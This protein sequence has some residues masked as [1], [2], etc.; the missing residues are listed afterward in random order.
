VELG[1]RGEAL[2]QE[3]IGVLAAH[4]DDELEV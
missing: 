1:V 3:V 4:V 2:S